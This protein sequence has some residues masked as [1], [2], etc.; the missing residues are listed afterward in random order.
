MSAL[1]FGPVTL[2]KRW[3][4]GS[5]SLWQCECGISNTARHSCCISCDGPRKF[6]EVA[7]SSGAPLRF[8]VGDPF[9]VD[10]ASEAD[11]YE[12]SFD[13]ALWKCAL[14]SLAATDDTTLCK[15]PE[16]DYTVDAS[17]ASSAPLMFG[18]RGS[19]AKPY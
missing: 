7:F 5:R 3:Q 19:I 15:P 17:A 6:T 8:Y 11:D 9:D 18:F 16:L 4:R 10:S 1:A 12:S 2:A 14:T 13:V